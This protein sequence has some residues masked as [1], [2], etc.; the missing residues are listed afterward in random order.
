MEEL[1]NN[2][3]PYSLSYSLTYKGIIDLKWQNVPLR[4]RVTGPI[5]A[6]KDAARFD[7]IPSAIDKEFVVDYTSGFHTQIANFLSSQK[8]CK[9]LRTLAASELHKKLTGQ[10]TE[11]ECQLRANNAVQTRGKWVLLQDYGMAVSTEITSSSVKTVFRVVDVS[12]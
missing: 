9:T 10:A 12:N 1:S 7:A 6:V 11:I 8:A 4:G 5:Y 3:I 2:D